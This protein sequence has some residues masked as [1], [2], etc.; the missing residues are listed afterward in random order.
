MVGALILY[1][2][3]QTK[4]FR[5]RLIQKRGPDYYVR[6]QT[7]FQTSCILL[8]PWNKI[9][10]I[11]SG[12]KRTILDSLYKRIFN[13]W[14][15][16]FI[17]A[18]KTEPE[19]VI[20]F[21]M[22]V[23]EPT[24]IYVPSYVVVNLGAVEQ[25]L[26]IH[27]VCLK[28]LQG[29]KSFAQ[30]T[31][32][33]IHEWLFPATAIRSVRYISNNKILNFLLQPMLQKYIINGYAIICVCY[34][35]DYTKRSSDSNFLKGQRT[36]LSQG[37]TIGMEYINSQQILLYDRSGCS[38]YKR[39]DRCVFLYVHQ[40]CDDFQMFFPSAILKQKFC[41]L[42][43]KMTPDQECLL[44]DLDSDTGPIQYE[45]EY[46]NT[47]RQKILGKGTY[48]IVYAARDLNTQVSIAIKEVP[49]KN[50]GDVQPLHEEIKLHSQLHHRNIV[51]YYGSVSED[52]LFKIFM[53][54]VPGG[55]LSQLLRSQW[56]P[57][58]DNER[59]I[60]FYT[61]QILEGLKYLHDQRI[62]HRD[63]KG[64]NV[65]IDT[66][67]GALKI[68]DFGTSKR[69]AAV[70]PNTDTFTVL[71]LNHIEKLMLR[72]WLY[73]T[74]YIDT[75]TTEASSNLSLFLLCKFTDVADIW[76]LGCT[77]VEMATGQ[78]P[79]QE[80]GSPQ[81]ALFQVGCFK[82][83][84]EIP[85]TM[86]EAMKRFIL[87]CFEPDPDK[88]ATAAELL[89]YPILKELTRKK[90]N[91]GAR[92]SITTPEYGRSISV[93]AD[94]LGKRQDK[95]GRF[96]STGD[97]GLFVGTKSSPINSFSRSSSSYSCSSI[98]SDSAIEDNSMSIRRQTSTGPLSPQSDTTLTAEQ[99]Q[100]GFY[101]LKKDSQRR[102]TIFTV[103]VEDSEK[104]CEMWFQQIGQ[105][106]NDFH[107]NI[108]HLQILLKGLREYIPEQNKEPIQFA[109]DMIMEDYDSEV[110]AVN[111]IKLA[112][113]TL[114]EAVN[115]ILRKRSIKPHW[116]FALDNLVRS[117]VV[118]AGSILSPEEI[119]LIVGNE[120]LDQEERSTSGVETINS[121]RSHGHMMSLRSK[122]YL[123]LQQKIST[124][125][126]E[127]LGYAKRREKNIP[128]FNIHNSIGVYQKYLHSL[129]NFNSHQ[130]YVLQ[131]VLNMQRKECGNHLL[132]FFQHYISTF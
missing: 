99:D 93:P 122:V 2:G 51:Q 128:G 118:A 111:E 21:P 22:L 109:I 56:G 126:D 67:R 125:E 55:S 10:C 20:R 27:N 130:V 34:T 11:T 87:A 42:L 72:L 23:L 131:I 101:L 3:N 57:L 82:I 43:L 73:S 37:A 123:E 5:N 75:A 66:Y 116:M 91:S 63:I 26:Q 69:L 85:E 32:N 86:S 16:Y 132:V 89:E 88:R 49:E 124:L 1:K 46:D 62:V 44:L 38:M 7:V 79:F 18:S 54:Q 33:Q 48:G 17:E 25:S 95:V 30:E 65:L 105:K 13:F 127:K 100:G 114:P 102:A 24:K 97:E 119:V 47:G 78:P 108:D 53:E 35:I 113:F 129:L 112:C 52:N 96:A 8:F 45:Y 31:C 92:L 15:D 50:I 81:A 61:K 14:L 12:F 29:R 107:L 106:I 58:K 77:V 9:P 60:A 117:A 4:A 76:S 115:P 19:D 41:D 121:A 36:V 83:H 90:K 68:S 40:N 98:T 110:S 6:T 84:P 39:D 80:L 94:K 28:C 103:L 71:Q 104:I 64:D 120:N 70:C 59:T 74:L